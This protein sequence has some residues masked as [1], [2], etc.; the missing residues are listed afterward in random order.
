MYLDKVIDY[1]KKLSSPEIELR[2]IIDPRQNAPKFAKSKL[3]IPQAI[4]WIKNKCDSLINENGAIS[5]VE[6]LINFIISNNQGQT[7]E[8]KNTARE[9]VYDAKT[10]KQKKQHTYIKSNKTNNIYIVSDSGYGA[11]LG[12]SEEKDIPSDSMDVGLADICRL[13]MR[14]SIKPKKFKNWKIDITLVKSAPANN[15]QSIKKIKE[16]LFV[17]TNPKNFTTD[18]NWEIADNIEVEAEYIGKSSKISIEDLKIID[19]FNSAGAVGGDEYQSAIYEIANILTPHNAHLYQGDVENSRG[20]KHLGNK[21][22]ELSRDAYYKTILAK[23][24]NYFV[25][26]KADGK[27]TLLYI[28]SSSNQLRIVNDAL[29]IVNNVKSK[30]ICIAD[31]EEII[32]NNIKKYYIFDVLVWNNEGVFAEPFAKRHSLIEE[33][34]RLYKDFEPKTYLS[35]SASDIA[36]IHD[37]KREY[38]I[39]GLIFTSK[40]KD[41]F[42]TEN[43]K[44]KPI[45][46]MTVDF[47]IK[48]CPRNLIGVAPYIPKKGENIYLLF[49]GIQRNYINKLNIRYMRYYKDLFGNIN[50]MGGYVPIRFMPSDFPYNHIFYSKDENLNSEV[51]EFSYDVKKQEWELHR[52]REDRRVE[53][54][55]GRYY[56]NDYRI[57]EFTWRSIQN[58]LT[59]E[60]LLK[61]DMSKFGY[62]KKDENNIY[63]SV[64]NFNSYVKGE[65]LA[66]YRGSEW[67]IDLSAGKGQDLFRFSMNR[68]RNVLF[69][70]KDDEA[71]SE[72]IRRKH[73]FLKDRKY[74]NNMGIYAQQMDLTTDYKANIE[75]IR[76]KGIPIPYGGVDLITMNFA[77]HYMCKDQKSLDNVI[78]LIYD[79]LAPGGRFIYTAFDGE[80]V[81]RILNEHKGQ[82]DLAESSMKY[83]IKAKSSLSKLKDY[84]QEIDV[85]LP[86]SNGEYYTEYL[87][88]AEYID[89]LF[90]KKKM[91]RELH[92]SFSEYFN[93]KPQHIQ[94]SSA[95]KEY[96]KLY[97]VN[98]FYKPKK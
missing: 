25:T 29:S 36:K 24:D 78:N 96:D 26:D 7:Y 9:L 62:F 4:N 45:N 27:R 90:A 41:Y 50:N 43:Y 87:V 77:F 64:R 73:D 60:E 97:Y 6:P 51:G 42:K 3:S 11:K 47:L 48:E 92:N 80:E 32:I 35:C 98:S 28:N 76:S 44:W 34:S 69:V 40:D 54:Q 74:Q 21:V 33:F 88:N 94:L 58:P 82:F 17:V 13:K 52:I 55:R 18:V 15:I 66:P 83:S 71:L 65:L 84:G 91:S 23:P 20:L 56:G 81:F 2:F 93:T 59:Y 86:F 57:A 31:S 1:I 68:M 70:D 46:Q 67:V 12:V 89:K 37:K 53:V 38:E 72:L 10:L 16:S 75:K 30:G 5:T 49:N 39:D 61:P 95:D 63:K 22:A 14:I 19:E 85:L 8:R 79:L